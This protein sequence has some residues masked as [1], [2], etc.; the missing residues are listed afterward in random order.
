[1]ALLL[2]A[3]APPTEWAVEATRKAALTAVVKQPDVKPVRF[4]YGLSPFAKAV[5]KDL[6]T[7]RKIDF[8]ALP[9]KLSGTRIGVT[10]TF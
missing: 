6:W 8:T 2:A 7:T 10:I 4:E 5:A 3:P 9:E 1:M